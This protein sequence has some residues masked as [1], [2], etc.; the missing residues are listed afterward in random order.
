[1]GNP[2]LRATDKDFPVF[3]IAMFI[4]DEDHYINVITPRV[5]TLKFQ[6]FG[7]EGIVLHSR[8]IRKA[9]GDFSI[10]T[11]PV[12]RESFIQELSAVMSDCEYQLLAVAIRKDKLIRQ[13]VYPADPYDLALLFAMERLVSV[14][15][16]A[17]QTDV[18]II[19]EKRGKNEDRELHVAFDRIVMRGTEYISLERFRAIRWRL[20][21]IPKSMNIIG[22]QMAD[23]A[24]Y[25]IARRVLDLEKHNPAYEVIRSKFC[26]VL[27]IFP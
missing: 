22:T 19:A 25:P 16:G 20:R 12:V 17:G 26:R 1:V 5:N 24:A 10:L 27:K 11:D 15:E 6:W 18:T 23:L 2:T 4:C 14:L 8:D 3:A 7:H 9:Q 21:F 13:Y